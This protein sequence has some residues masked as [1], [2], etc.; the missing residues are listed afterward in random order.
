MRVERRLSIPL[1][2]IPFVVGWIC[3]V[4]GILRGLAWTWSTYPFTGNLLI[5]VLI[6]RSIFALRPQ[7]FLW[8]AVGA[9]GLGLVVFSHIRGRPDALG[10]RPGLL[11][12]S[13]RFYPF[14]FTLGL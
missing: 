12:A 1:R 9:V 4:L 3:L 10:A 14:L 5:Q 6:S 11:G 2:P 7:N 8:L 13:L